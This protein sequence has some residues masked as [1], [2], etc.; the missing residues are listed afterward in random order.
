LSLYIIPECYAN[1][2][3]GELVKESIGNEFKGKVH[4]IHKKWFGRDR[5]LK[6]ILKLIKTLKSD[7]VIAII[8]YEEGL[9]RRYI[10]VIRSGKL[11]D[12][13][14]TEEGNIDST[15]IIRCGSRLK[16]IIF[17][18]NIEHVLLR[19]DKELESNP[20]KYK[21]EKAE[22][23]IIKLYEKNTKFKEYLC[24]LVNIVT[25]NLT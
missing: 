7:Y 22:R 14:C 17:D 9:Y 24:S 6:E 3:V 12:L 1:K 15:L 20:M 11:K 5:V 21:G 10:D 13:S 18:S 8:D 16:L 19:Y 25:R 23:E 4:V 2:G